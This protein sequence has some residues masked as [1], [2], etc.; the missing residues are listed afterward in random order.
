MK[1]CSHL[2]GRLCASSKP[3][4]ISGGVGGGV[5]QCLSWSPEL[6]PSS[7]LQQPG[8]G[9]KLA[10]TSWRVRKLI[11]IIRFLLQLWSWQTVFCFGL[12]FFC[13]VA[14][15]LCSALLR[16]FRRNFRKQML[17]LPNI[18]CLVHRLYAEDTH[19]L[20]VEALVHHLVVDYLFLL[21]LA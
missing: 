1:W 14:F 9:P 8:Q 17:E 2:C 11:K 13:I 15:I 21:D 3:G 18:L 6:L 16:N 10:S 5:M 20:L 12:V 4:V 7:A 19:T